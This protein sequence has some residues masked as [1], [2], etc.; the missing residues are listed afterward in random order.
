MYRGGSG[1]LHIEYLDFIIDIDVEDGMNLSYLSWRKKILINGDAQ[2][3]SQGHT[4]GMPLMFPTPNRTK[5][6]RYRYKG[7]EYEA[8]MHGLFRNLPFMLVHNS[9]EEDTYNIT[10]ILKWGPDYETFKTY[11]FECMLKIHIGIQHKCI[12]Y[13]YQLTNCGETTMPYGFG[14]HPF[15]ENPNHDAS[16][17]TKAKTVLNAHQC[18]NTG[19][20]QAVKG[21][22]Y[23]LFKFKSVDTLNLD[24]VYM[25][26]NKTDNLAEVATI[27]WSD[28]QLSIHCSKDFSHLLIYTPENHDKF[29]IEPQTCSIDAF[30]LFD[31]GYRK[32]SGVEE[33]GKNETK[34]GTIQF[35]VSESN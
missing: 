15:F 31:E 19:E 2:R 12:F 32:I 11:P 5:N 8:R 33:V 18:L 3:K 9:E 22:P 13:D 14:V 4:Y 27:H 10:G 23:D 29:C 34:S 25:P 7:V 17:M 24:T 20:T 16:I 1:M 6:N 26:E 30:N 35:I 28:Y 21:T